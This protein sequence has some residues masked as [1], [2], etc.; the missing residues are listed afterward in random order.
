MS[1]IESAQN[2]FM[3]LQV[4]VGKWSGVAQLK[5]GSAKAAEDAG[6]NP[7]ASRL[8]VNLLG[9]HHADLKRVNS[10]FSAVRTYL[11]EN[12]LPFSNAGEGQQKRGDRLV[13]VTSLPEVLS[14]L[15]ELK[16]DAQAELDAFLP[17]YERLRDF[18]VAHDLGDWRDEVSFPTA[19]E[20]ADKFYASISTPQPIPACDVSHLNLPA[21]LAAKIA[22]QHQA[23][24]SSQLEGAKDA[25]IEGA[26]EHM[27]TVEKQLTD[28]KRLHQSL[29]D[30][31]RRHADLLRG[32]VSGYDNDPRVL[33]VAD[34]IDEQISSIGDINKVKHSET[35]R[36]SAV[37]A[38]KTAHKSLGEIA[39][40]QSTAQPVAPAAA[41]VVSG[42]SLLADLID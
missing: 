13:S 7:E 35:L 41:T 31:A 37:R 29:I 17:Q 23:A 19:S 42:D 1:F 21:S 3:T 32:M 8:Y 27:S 10:K 26:R 36:Q 20:V 4:S 24:L 40:A 28:G 2:N 33:A 38:A 5:R 15:G 9:S 30:G 18:A 12:T 6:A 16:A 11:Y 25:A 14:R 39:A 34:L 22:E